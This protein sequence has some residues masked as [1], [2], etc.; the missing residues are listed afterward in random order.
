MNKALGIALCAWLAALPAAAQEGSPNFAQVVVS[1]L[2]LGEPIRTDQ[3]ILFPLVLA[4]APGEVG[5]DPLGKDVTFAEPDGGTRRHDVRIRN[6][7]ARPVLVLGGTILEGGVRDRLIATDCLVPAGGEATVRAVPAAS[8][9]DVRKEPAPFTVCPSLAPLYLRRQAEFSSSESLVPTFVARWIDFR[10]DG[11][12][13]NS[14]VAICESNELMEYSL[15]SRERAAA[16][17]AGL[18]GQTVV[19]GIG[20]IRGRIQ[21]VTLF[22]SN[23]LVAAN[24]DAFAR[25]AMFGAAAIEIRAKAAGVPLPGQGD[26]EKTFEA[27]K[28]AAGELLLKLK[29][30]SY[31]RDATPAGAAGDVLVVKLGG[32]R[33]GRAVGLGGK[34]VHLSL[35]PYDPV[36]GRLYSGAVDPDAK[37]EPEEEK[38]PDEEDSPPLTEEEEGFVNSFRD[39]VRG[40]RGGGRR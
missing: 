5:V 25:S 1:R 36:E 9:S 40:G 26:P 20:A 13:R 11:D 2:E 10:N 29:A 19:G 6:G 24:F 8:S 31:E 7:G 34:L 28:K 39:R 18:E 33:R 23:D 14:L 35:Y 21:A 32:G 3:A 16:L 4:D 30:A 27:V 38:A 37:P 17:P 15:R 12:K 22:G